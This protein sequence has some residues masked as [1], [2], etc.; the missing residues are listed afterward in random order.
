M[1]GGIRRVTP[2]AAGALA[3]LHAQCF[4]TAWP[5]SEFAALLHMPGMAGFLWSVNPA[6]ASGFALLRQVVDE[7][8]ILTIGIAPSGRGQGAGAELLR[9]VEAAM[10]AQGV[11]RVFLEVS[12][13]NASA[14]RLY[15]RAGYSE[16]GRRRHYYADGTDAL[17]LEK[18]LRKDGQTGI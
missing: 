4:D 9:A 15:D 13:A 10:A 3:R 16:I 1:N 12:T 6:G 14:R 7:A 2:Q 18:W 17:V 11:A 8:E 5:E